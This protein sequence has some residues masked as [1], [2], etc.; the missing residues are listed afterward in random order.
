MSRIDPADVS[1]IVIAKEPLPGLAKTRLAP[2]LTPEDAARVAEACLIDTLEAV[3]ATPAHRRVLVLDGEPGSWLPA[4]AGFELVPQRAGDLGERLAG[5]FEDSGAAPA[6]LVGMDTPQLTPALLATAIETLSSAAVDAVLGPA[7]DGGY[8]AIGLRAADRAVF[9][10]V[11]MSAADTGARQHERLGQ[12]GLETIELEPLR[13]IDTIEDARA[14]AA[15]APSTRCS[16]VL[17]DVD[18]EGSDA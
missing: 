6:V 15:A 7:D 4:G 5:A 14:V 12:L 8:W 17:R 1:L 2:T 3:A 13:D 11:P 9:E 10:D 16:R 18:P